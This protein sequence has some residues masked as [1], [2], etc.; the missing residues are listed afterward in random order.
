MYIVKDELPKSC[1]DCPFRS[2]CSVWEHLLSMP[3]DI[4]EIVMEDLDK[5]KPEMNYSCK[6]Y[7]V[8]NRFENFY[9]KWV[10]GECRHICI[11]C[12]YKK[13]CGLCRTHG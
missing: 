3:A 10:I 7:H 6:L 2:S 13:E 1:F 4:A 8:Q 11:F 12:K 9:T 5:F